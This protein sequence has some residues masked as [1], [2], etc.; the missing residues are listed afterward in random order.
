M[1]KKIFKNLQTYNRIS[2]VTLR[3]SAASGSPF[4]DS[5]VV[6][7]ADMKYSAYR[8]FRFEFFLL[9]FYAA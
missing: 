3:L 9:A 7:I 5:P 8:L 2:F 1:P 6:D 4:L